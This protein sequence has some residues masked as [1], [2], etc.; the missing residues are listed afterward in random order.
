[1]LAACERSGV[2]LEA[3][4]PLGHG[5]HLQS[6]AVAQIA[7]RLGRTPAHVLLR[8]CI[9]RDLPVIPKSKNRD[10][11]EQNG[12]VFD[13]ALSAQDMAALDALDETGGTERAQENKWW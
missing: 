13:F 5:R 7:E 1:L 6:P 3:Y 10:R 2:V 11:I 8:W 9:E 4:S 12:D